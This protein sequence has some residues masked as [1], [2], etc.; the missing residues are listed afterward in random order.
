MENKEKDMNFNRHAAIY[1]A[2]FGR[3]S[4]RFYRMLL[5]QVELTPG[6]AV[7]DAACGTGEVL[8]RMAYICP[9]DG[10]GID[11][12]E[13]MVAMAKRKCPNMDIRLSRC[14]NTPFADNTFDIITVCMAYHHF[15]EKAGFAKEAARIIKPGGRL[16]IADPN[17]PRAIR[18]FINAF[19]KALRVAGTFHTPEEMYGQFAEC[20]FEPAGYIKKGYAQVVKMKMHR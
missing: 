2:A 10:Y 3:A 6:A 8:R 5:E 19:F 14:E 12:S 18:K 1:D 17:Y 20:G 4:E 13:N 11:M 15:S 7:L 9:V 16:Y